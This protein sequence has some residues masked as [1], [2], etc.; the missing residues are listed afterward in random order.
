MSWPGLACG[1]PP[2]LLCPPS[3]VPAWPTCVPALDGVLA[4]VP[5]P[6]TDGRVRLWVDRSFTI[7]GSGTVVTGTLA[8]GTL[9]QGDRL[10]LLGHFGSRSV[11]VRGLQSRDTS[12]SSVAPVSRVALEPA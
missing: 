7:T 11:V 4:S 6:A 12:Y 9:A 3:T 1:T 10:Q 2:Q 5:A 8:A